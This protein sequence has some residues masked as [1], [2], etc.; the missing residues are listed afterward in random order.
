MTG[1]LIL[2]IIL[3]ILLIALYFAFKLY[4]KEKKERLKAEA[5]SDKLRENIRIL[6]DNVSAVKEIKKKKTG[7]DKK[8]KEAQTNEEVDNII[9]DIIK[10]NNDRVY[11]G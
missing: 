9:L 2:F 7:I 6:Q 8:I 1:Y 5:T 3:V 10:S 11:N 4:N